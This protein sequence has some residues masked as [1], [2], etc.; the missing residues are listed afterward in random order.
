MNPLLAPGLSPAFDEIQAQHI[1]PAVDT[2]LAAAQAE[3]DRI[4]AA[5]TPDYPAVVLALDRATEPLD[6]A[7]AIIGHLESVRT[8]P[9]LRDAYNAV[10]PSVAEFGA[11]VPL[12]PKLWGAVRQ[13]TDA[14]EGVHRRFLTKTQRGF[15]RAGADLAPNDKERLTEINVELAQVTTRFGQNALDATNAWD[16]VVK[17][18]AELAGLPPSAI[19]AARQSALSKSLD[20][21]R[22]TLQAPSVKAVLTYL[23]NPGIREQ[24]WRAQ[25]TRASSGE[26]NNA[27]LIP[28]VLRLR[29]EKASLL[30][31][32]NFADFV[33]EERMAKSGTR[34]MAFLDELFART[35]PRFAEERQELE[36]FAARPL[37]PWDVGY[38]AEKQRRALYDFDEE[39]LRPYFPLEGVVDGMFRIFEGL[40]GLQ[41]SRRPEILG[42]HA[43]VECFEIRTD[44]GRV[45]GLFYTDWFPREN[46]RDGA[47][48]DA[49]RTGGPGPGPD[50]F[51]PHVGLMC[52]NLTP[53]V[54]GRPAL[55]THREVETVFHEFGHL[56]H[57]CL[58]TVEVRTLS[59]TRVAWDFVE[60]PS[61]IMENW[62]WE[63][64]ALSRFARHWETGEPV[65]TAMFDRMKRARNFRAATYQMR[66]LSFGILDLKLHTGYD[67]ARDGDVLDYSRR[68]MQPMS[69]ATL[70]DDYAMVAGF[71]HLFNDPVG[72]GAGYY[73]Y[74]WGEVLDADAFSRFQREG[75][76]NAETGAA[77]RKEVLE[78]GC[79]EEP[80][81]LYRAFMGRDPDLSALLERNGL[82]AAQPVR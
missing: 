12:N 54:A 32:D 7:M 45:A 65:P 21:W 31:F 41:I 13:V 78:K 79:S 61:Q 39:A 53:P 22:F 64:D 40:F 10:L 34:A 37:E 29:A 56:L 15:R 38:W 76:F 42:W 80:E 82:L 48:M 72:Y 66:Q 28:Q 33:L 8:A 44:D 59:G 70:P 17:D 57:Q 51:E 35:A 71:T 75:I 46:K 16:L 24:V 60:L 73:S 25:A 50:G 62:C 47:W 63:R 30:G 18:E 43:D 74:K 5:A 77:F 9:E 20:G 3:I 26:T 81:M 11:S 4:A 58:S 68:V 55:L 49:L 69:T 14:P 1:Q 36:A 6:H 19:D 2:L 52:G 23:D 67:P 27:E